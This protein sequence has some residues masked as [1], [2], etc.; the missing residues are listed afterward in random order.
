MQ[1]QTSGKFGGLGIEV[2]MEDGI[3][4]VVSPIDDTPAAKAGILANDEIIAIDGDSVQ[5][6]TL[7]Q[8]VDKMRGADQHPDHADH[9]ARRRRQAVRRQAG[10]RRDHHP[11]G[12]LARR[13]RRRLHP[14]H[15]VQ[16]ADLRRAEEPIDKL[17]TKIGADKVQGLHH[18]PAQQPGRPARPGDRGLRRLPR[19]GRGR[20]DP[21]PPCRRDPALQRPGRRPD[22]RQAG[23][24][25]DQRRLRLGLRDRRR[26]AAGP[27]PRDHHRHPLASAR[28]RCRRSSRSAATA[29]SA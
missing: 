27:P 25:A 8:A 28:A 24:R 26:R 22:R 12:A 4:K 10:A 16:R 1:V 5:G 9:Q 23:D 6:M 13:G 19:P 7:N 11:G 15:L 20:L 14:H 3:I 2:T 17:K 18:R 29:R 21:R